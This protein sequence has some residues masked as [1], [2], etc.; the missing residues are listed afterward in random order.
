[1]SYADGARFGHDKGCLPGI[2][3]GIIYQ[4]VHSD[5]D[6]VPRMFPLT[7]VAGSGKSSITPTVALLFHELGCFGS[8]FCFDLSHLADRRP[9]NV[10]STIAR[11]LADMGP[12][13][14]HSLWQLIWDKRFGGRERH[15]RAV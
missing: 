8:S 9:D 5:G 15:P 4:W 3:K 14:K 12:Q 10:F 7:G 6:G 2:R 13:R 11:D 1:M